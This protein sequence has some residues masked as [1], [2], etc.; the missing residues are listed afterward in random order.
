MARELEAASLD[1]A[2]QARAVL[3]RSEQVADLGGDDIAVARLRMEDAAET[4]LALALAVL[5]GGVVVGD[6]GVV[7]G[8]DD[9]V[10]RGVVDRQEALAERGAA[11]AETGHLHV[12]LAEPDFR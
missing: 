11:E 2:R 3:R 1:L 7:S 4:R 12:R 9:G 10:R 5:R 6:P 8:L